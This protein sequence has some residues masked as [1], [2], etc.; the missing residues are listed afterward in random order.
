MWEKGGCVPHLAL[1]TTHLIVTFNSALFSFSELFSP[2]KVR[3]AVF[4]LFFLSSVSTAETGNVFHISTY[5]CPVF[6]KLPE[7]WEPFRTAC[8]SSMNYLDEL[9]ASTLLKR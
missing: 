2:L 3:G 5:F 8:C 4:S 7:M 6:L 1:L 9:R